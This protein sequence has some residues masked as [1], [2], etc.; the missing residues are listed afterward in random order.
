MFKTPILIM[1][2]PVLVDID[3]KEKR[4]IFQKA[5]LEWDIFNK[6]LSVKNTHRNQT[7]YCGDCV[8]CAPANEKNGSGYVRCDVDDSSVS[9]SQKCNK[10]KFSLRFYT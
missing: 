3:L 1:Y 6:R 9:L 10:C 7:K 2:N 5:I 4:D 8:H